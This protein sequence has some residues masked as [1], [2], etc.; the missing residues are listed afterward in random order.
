[1]NEKIHLHGNNNDWTRCGI[2]VN[3]VSSEQV[4]NNVEQCTCRKCAIYMLRDVMNRYLL[5]EER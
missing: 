5:L 4:T 2:L 1:M 3:N